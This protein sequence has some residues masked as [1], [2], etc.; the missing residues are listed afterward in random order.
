LVDV[1]THVSVKTVTVGQDAYDALASVKRPGESFSEVVRRITGSQMMLSEFAG[2]WSDAPEQ[3][4]T[5][6]REFLR[7]SDRASRVEPLRV[8]TRRTPRGGSR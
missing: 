8:A 2:A 5:S 6:L 7:E 1:N 4:I 3:E